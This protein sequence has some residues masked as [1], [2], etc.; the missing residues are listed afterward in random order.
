[1][2][3]NPEIRSFLHFVELRVVLFRLAFWQSHLDLPLIL[4]SPANLFEACGR[5]IAFLSI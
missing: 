5:Q 1:M 4:I 3:P 2:F